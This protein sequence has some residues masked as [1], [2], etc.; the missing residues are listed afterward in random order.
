MGDHG[1]LDLRQ[2]DAETVREQHRRIANQLEGRFPDAAALLDEAATDLLAFTGFPKEHWQLWWNNSL[3][4]LNKKIRRRT[5]AVGIFPDRPS[6]VR[7]VGAILCRAS[8]TSGR[9]PAAT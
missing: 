8:R 9:W 7:L 2:P 3:E 1:A 4:R 5:H 6:I